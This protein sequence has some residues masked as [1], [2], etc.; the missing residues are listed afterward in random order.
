MKNAQYWVA[1]QCIL[2]Y[3]ANEISDIF[4][5]F[6]DVSELFDKS[7]KISDVDF[8]SEKKF[9]KLKAFDLRKSKGIVDYCRR[10]N[11]EIIT[12][13]DEKYPS[14]LRMI[15]NPPAVLYVRGKMPD[16]D[17][18]LGIGMVGTRKSSMNGMIAASTLAY[19]IAQAGGVVISGGAYGIDTKCTQGALFAKKPSVIVRP[20]GLEYN[21]LKSLADIRNDVEKCGAV[22]S[23][24]QPFGRV[25]RDAFHIRNRIIS[26]LSN[27]IVVIEAPEKSGVMIT[28]RHALEYGKDVFAIPGD[29][30]DD[31]YRGSNKLLQDGAIP[32]YTAADVLNEYI[33]DFPHKLNLDYASIPI[34]EDD[35]YLKLQ[36]K[37]SK[38][39]LTH[40]QEPE[41]QGR[42]TTFVSRVKSKLV[43]EE[44]QNIVPEI[45]KEKLLELPFDA[46]E[47]TKTVYKCF[48]DKPVSADYI[49]EKSGL[50]AGEVMFALTELEI[51]DVINS[52]PGGRF[53][54]K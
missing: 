8:I 53:E 3:G 5:N 22:I 21:Y 4:E 1:L 49:S 10:K 39:A 45:K 31:N 13:D 16:F 50:D 29:L 44:K 33:F 6:E 7:L 48:S 52:L 18:E 27:G 35:V 17:E 36:K 20:C 11:I 34:N 19:R 2:G 14:L 40:M 38:N 24:V 32:V 28:V 41:K 54:I 43:K 42:K 25:E 15:C 9:K 51:N 37:Y 23:E 47:N 12:I 46:D 26:A 30:A